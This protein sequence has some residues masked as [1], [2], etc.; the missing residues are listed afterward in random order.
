MKAI[1]LHNPHALLM[2]LGAKANETRS[3]YTSH[4]GKLAIHAS[5]SREWEA[6]FYRFKQFADCLAGRE[7]NQL[8][9]GAV[10][11]IVTLVDCV[12]APRN[13]SNEFKAT[14]EYQFGNYAPGRFIWMTENPRRLREPVY[15]RG[16]QSL[17]DWEPPA[18]CR[19]FMGTAI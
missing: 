4:R 12:E 13:Q 7:W 2:A 10:I 14:N 18:D 16:Y 6:H 19:L 15:T 3:W 8:A 9:F 1:T 5:K 11:A 17:W